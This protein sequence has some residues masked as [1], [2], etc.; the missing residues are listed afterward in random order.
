MSEQACHLPVLLEAA[1]YALAAQ[2]TRTLKKHEIVHVKWPSN[3][4]SRPS[5]QTLAGVAN[6]KKMMSSGA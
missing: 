4:D 5:D 1:A 6:R 3:L 2:C